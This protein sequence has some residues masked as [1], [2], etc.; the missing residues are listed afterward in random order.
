MGP[1]SR[2]PLRCS[3]LRRVKLP[4]A[5]GM[6]PVSEQLIRYTCER[7]VQFPASTCIG[8]LNELKLR[9]GTSESIAT[10]VQLLETSQTPDRS[11]DAASE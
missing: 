9:Y 7:L 5:A 8:P 11:R 4:I 1:V 2:L 3:S 6:L 10:E